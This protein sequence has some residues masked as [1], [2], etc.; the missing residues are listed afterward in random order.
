MPGIGSLH[1]NAALTNLAVAYGPQ[2]MIADQIFTPLGVGKQSDK[3]FIVDAARQDLKSADDRRGQTGDPNLI[4]FAVSNDSYTCDEH[5]LGDLVPFAEQENADT[6]LN[7]KMDSTKQILSRLGINKEI[8]AESICSSSIT[9]TAAASGTTSKW[10]ASDATPIDDVQ[11]Q[12]AAVESAVGMT[13]NTGWCDIAVYRALRNSVQVKAAIK[14][15]VLTVAELDRVIADIL[16][17]DRIIVSKA[18]KNTSKSTTKSLSAIWGK[19]FYLGYINPMAAQKSIT[20]GLTFDWKGGN[21]VNGYAVSE[22]DD[23]WKKAT[24]IQAARWY[25]QK[26]VVAA[27]AA[28]VT[29]CIA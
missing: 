28:K 6:P 19:V 5:V 29:A 7:P 22:E 3:Y 17:L 9:Q 12:I 27:A 24:K 15:G 23:N 11:T 25:D 4:D 13:P 16:G 2:V 18:K 8:A 26:V 14:S 10:A 1:I 21:T 20:F